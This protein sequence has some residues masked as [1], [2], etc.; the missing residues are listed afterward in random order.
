MPYPS[1]LQPR[2]M[3]SSADVAAQQLEQALV[4]E[5]LHGRTQELTRG[6]HEIDSQYLELKA[7]YVAS[8]QALTAALGPRAHCNQVDCDLWSAFSGLYK[9]SYGVRPRGHFSRTEAQEH[10]ARM[11]ATPAAWLTDDAIDDGVVC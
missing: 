5:A 7:R 3:P 9:A 11:A 10:L 8:V 2:D 4:R 6:A 1:Y